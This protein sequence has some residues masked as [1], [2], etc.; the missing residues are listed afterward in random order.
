MTIIMA[1]VDCPL[2]VVTQ[3]HFLPRCTQVGVGVTSSPA[4]TALY[5]HQYSMAKALKNI[6]T[7]QT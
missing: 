6:L 2:S 1:Y 4:E 3:Y 7:T 5:G